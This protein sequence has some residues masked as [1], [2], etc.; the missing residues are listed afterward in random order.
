M[1]TADPEPVAILAAGI[2]ATPR[3]TRRDEMPA[4]EW[5]LQWRAWGRASTPNAWQAASRPCSEDVAARLG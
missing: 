2:R 3:D 5:D 4:W 1:S